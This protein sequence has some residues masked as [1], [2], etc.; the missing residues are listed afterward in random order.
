V[1]DGNFL[2]DCFQDEGTVR[3]GSDS[4]LRQQ[5]NKTRKLFPYLKKIF[6]GVH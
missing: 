2:P 5:K 4:P 1:R 3:V 6:A